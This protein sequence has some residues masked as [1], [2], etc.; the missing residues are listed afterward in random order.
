LSLFQVEFRKIM[1]IKDDGPEFGF[2]HVIQRYYKLSERT[3]CFYVHFIR[4]T[5][6]KRMH[7]IKNQ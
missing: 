2:T 7:D 3:T 6:L 1:L 5:K 4:T